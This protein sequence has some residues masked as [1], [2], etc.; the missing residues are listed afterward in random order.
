M[1]LS[2]D[3]SAARK[4]DNGANEGVSS[5]SNASSP[6][7]PRLEDVTARRTTEAPDAAADA[8]A[9]AGSRWARLGRRQK[10]FAGLGAVAVIALAVFGAR[11]FLVGRYMIST[12]D[13]YVRA[14]NTMLGARASGYLAKIAVGDNAE[15]KAGDL[16]FQIDD[17]DYKLAV[18]NARAKIATQEAT[19]KRIGRQAI[20]QQSA[21]EQAQAQLESAQAAA[22]RAEADFVRQT[23]LS[24]KGFASKAT[25]DQSQATRDQSNASVQGAQANLDAAQAQIDVIKAQQSEA[26]GQLGELKT[27]LAK[28]ERDLSF[29]TIRA[30]IDGVFSNR[31]V[32][33][34]D[35]IQV[36]QR[37]ANEVPLDDVFIDANFKETQLARMR[38]GQPV[39][40]NV[41]AVK[42]RDIMGTVESLSPAS[43][44]VFTL[45]PPDNATGN[46]TKIVQR[47]PVR[48]RVPKTVAHENLLRAGMSVEVEV[49]TRKPAKQAVAKA[50]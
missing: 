45:L 32:N 44:S 18:D 50:E 14:N 8:P 1:A 27:A 34:G 36:G 29:T 48:V 30:P 31:L 2:R 42:G 35:N 28:A 24:E 17:G 40:I 3:Q 37:L 5:P 10:I 49:D 46:F 26:E 25:F 43:G 20:A 22:K 47:L 23:Q 11:Y 4:A 39:Y 38:P 12:D 15:V 7:R 16:L 6:A 41:D 33:E 9:A 19:I 21:V 13:A